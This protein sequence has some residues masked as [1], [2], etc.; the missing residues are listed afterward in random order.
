MKL[1]KILNKKQYAEYCN[2]VLEL[3]NL[4]S[5]GK[6]MPDKKELTRQ[7]FILELIIEHYENTQANP[8]AKLNPVDLLK[9][10]MVEY[11]YSGRKLAKELKI[12]ESVISEILNYKRRFSKDVVIK[13]A[14]KFNMGEILL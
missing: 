13:L 14:K 9:A 12:P 4:L 2:R 11:A 5:T 6:N 1:N 10:L 8:F 3:S 7:L